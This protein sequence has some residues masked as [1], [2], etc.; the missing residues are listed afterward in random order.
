MRTI[1][2]SYKGDQDAHWGGWK[3]TPM[4]DRERLRVF[5]PGR[6]D[7]NF[8]IA[9]SDFPIRAIVQPGVR[10]AIVDGVVTIFEVEG[11][12]HVAATLRHAGARPV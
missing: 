6:G 11:A 7:R 10:V 8:E 5:S 4:N 1:K 2:I 12:S 3:G 9:A